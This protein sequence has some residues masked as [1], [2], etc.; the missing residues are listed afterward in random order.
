MRYLQLRQL[1]QVHR[2]MQAADPD[3]VSVAEV[4]VAHGEWEFSRFAARYRRLFG[5]LPSQTLRTRA[6]PLKRP[7]GQVA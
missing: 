4:L 3:N 1:H 7:H 2:A 5:E 6:R